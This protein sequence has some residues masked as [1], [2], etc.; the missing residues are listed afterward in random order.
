L[1][2]AYVDTEGLDLSSPIMGAAARLHD[3]KAHALLAKQR[4]NCDRVSRAADSI[5]QLESANASWK[6]FFARSTA[7]VVAFISGS[8]WLR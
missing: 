4:W 3:D 8:S 6:T 1:P 5:L 7:T 2:N